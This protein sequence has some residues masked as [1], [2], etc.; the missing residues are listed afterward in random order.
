M[1]W[2]YRIFRYKTEDEEYY[3]LHEA[4][5]DNSNKVDDYTVNPIVPRGE[6]VEE[7]LT[8]LRMMLTD[9]EKSKGDI[10]EYEP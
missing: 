4:Y 9:A 3:E 6:S 10:L 1:T 7:L 2:N 5:Y 8:C